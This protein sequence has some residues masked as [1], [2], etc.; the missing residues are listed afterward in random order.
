MRDDSSG[1]CPVQIPFCF[2]D[3]YARDKLASTLANAIGK[4]HGALGLK[5]GV[6]LGVVEGEL[7]RDDARR[8]RVGLTSEAVE[9][10]VSQGSTGYSTVGWQSGRE[11]GR[12]T[13]GFMVEN[14]L[15]LNPG[16]LNTYFNA[17][18]AHEIG[19]LRFP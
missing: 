10:K 3:A 19:E 9:V 7:C 2:Q 17:L 12:M 18:M 4:W 8:W 1:R 14:H 13:L 6:E 15:E 16:Q 5:R 11:P